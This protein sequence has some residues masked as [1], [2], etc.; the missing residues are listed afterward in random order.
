MRDLHEIAGKARQAFYD[1]SSSSLELRNQVLHQL[2]AKL[3]KNRE[4]IFDANK[5]DL[6]EAEKDHL[7]MPMLH[8]LSFGEEK[9]KQV[10][11]GLLSLI[12]L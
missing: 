3:D 8:L 5:K 4:I 11:N 7:S 10:I 9:L 12:N 1:I 6:S 2:A